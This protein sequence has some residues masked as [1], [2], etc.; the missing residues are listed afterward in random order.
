MGDELTPADFERATHDAGF[1]AFL[2][3]QYGIAEHDLPPMAATDGTQPSRHGFASPTPEPTAEEFRRD[4]NSGSSSAATPTLYERAKRQAKLVGRDVA[5]GLAGTASMVVG[6]FAFNALDPMSAQRAAGIISRPVERGLDA[7]DVPKPNPG[8]EQF[9]HSGI[10]G[11]A[12]TAG[13]GGPLVALSGATGGMGADLAQQAGGGTLAQLAGGVVGG[14]VGGIPAMVQARRSGAATAGR[15]LE[16]ASKEDAGPTVTAMA[17]G[18]PPTERVQDYLVRRVGGQG[19]PSADRL[20]QSATQI[21]DDFMNQERGITSTAKRNVATVRQGARQTLSALRNQEATTVGMAKEQGA[22][23]VDRATRAASG[24][25]VS[26]A[27]AQ[28]AGPT[29]L[30]IQQATAQAEAALA[31]TGRRVFD[32]LNA[33]GELDPSLPASAAVFDA[34]GNPQVRAIYEGYAPAVPHSPAFADLQRT[35]RMLG[36]R[37]TQAAMNGGETGNTL[38]GE[39]FRARDELGAAMEKAYPKFREANAAYRADAVRVEALADGYSAIKSGKALGPDIRQRMADVHGTGGEAALDAYQYGQRRAIRD[40]LNAQDANVDAATPLTRLGP[41]PEER[42]RTAFP[43]DRSARAFQGEVG[44]AAA[45]VRRAT[46]TAQSGEQGVARAFRTQRDAVR[47]RASEVVADIQA[48][49]QNQKAL[50]PADRLRIAKQIES[51]T[52]HV[53]VPEGGR[54]IKGLA[55]S[56]AGASARGKVDLLF[57][58]FGKKGDSEA[59]RELL[60]DL[61]VGSP[62]QQRAALQTLRAGTTATRRAAGVAATVGGAQVDRDTLQNYLLGPK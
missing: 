5:E 11:A 48:Q 53:D 3:Q 59:A 24:G 33:L 16:R 57:G 32:P 21:I 37:G 45:N 23:L 42:L 26:E 56:A 17:E 39:F 15:I 12:S 49:A 7:L 58:F 60:T 62:K 55:E 38:M 47:Q 30:T 43:N 50:L 4:V 52:R 40:N 46:A 13:V 18:A 2:T 1:R 36:I 10:R 54:A 20:R 14:V 25:P 22:S 41:D 51:I 35:Y 27:F 29:P 61:L 28:R 19:G 9:I 44:E 34:L 8:M 31:E 6:P